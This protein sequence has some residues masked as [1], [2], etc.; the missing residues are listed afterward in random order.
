MVADLNRFYKE[1]PALWELDHSPEGFRWIDANDAD[2]NVI[3]FYRTGTTPASHLVCVANFSTVPREGF[4]VGLPKKGRFEEVLN[5][6]SEIYGGSGVGN[7]GSVVAEPV[8]WHGLDHSA[9]M[10]LPPLGV[11]WLRG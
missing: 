11:V 9:V 8:S 5:T 1:T 2:N 6:D 7:M 10:T 4:R 3:S